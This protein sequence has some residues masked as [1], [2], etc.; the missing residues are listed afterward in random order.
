MTATG[1]DLAW[2]HCLGSTVDSLARSTTMWRR[3]PVSKT[4]CYKTTHKQLMTSASYSNLC[5]IYLY[6][7]LAGGGAPSLDDMIMNSI[8]VAGAQAASD[9]LLPHLGVY[10]ANPHLV[11]HANCMEAGLD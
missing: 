5:A 6:L 1:V 4:T 2:M 7:L 9:S 10:A 8:G 3:G 11:C